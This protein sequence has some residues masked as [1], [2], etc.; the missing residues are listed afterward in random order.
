MEM[1]IYIK[2]LIKRR[3]LFTLN[4]FVFI[5]KLI[6]IVKRILEKNSKA[7]RKRFQNCR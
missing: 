3:S 2:K 5:S 6:D 1:G 4:L 7:A